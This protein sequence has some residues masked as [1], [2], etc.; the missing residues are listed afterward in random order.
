MRF[1]LVLDAGAYIGEWTARATKEQKGMAALFGGG[2]RSAAPKVWYRLHAVVVHLGS[3]GGGHYI[4]YRR[5]YRLARDEARGRGR[6]GAD[7]AF[8]S[9]SSAS[10]GD[11]ANSLRPTTGPYEEEDGAVWKRCSDDSVKDA[12]VEE[13]LKAQ[14]YLLFYHRI[15]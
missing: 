14:A 7:A 3:A 11:S 10:G 9:A 12:T 15:R 8:S 1:P 5:H 6:P 4:C 2:G 13:V